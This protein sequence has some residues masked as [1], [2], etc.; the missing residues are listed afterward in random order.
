M[1]AGFVDACAA[2]DVD[3]IGASLHRLE[4]IG[5]PINPRVSSFK[6]AGEGDEVDFGQEV[7]EQGF[8]GSGTSSAPSG[9]TRSV[10]LACRHTRMPKA[11]ASE[12]EPC[13]DTAEPVDEQALARELVLALRRGCETMPR[14]CLAR[15]WSRPVWIC[16]H[17]REHER[18]RVLG[19]GVRVDS[20]SASPARTPASRRGAARSKRSYPGR[21]DLDEAK[22]RRVVEHRIVP[23][24]GKYEHVGFSRS[25]LEGVFHVPALEVA[26]AGLP[27]GEALGKVI[28]DVCEVHGELIARRKE[29]QSS[30]VWRQP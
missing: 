17:E 15:W 20:P 16:L 8:G 29:A 24:T 25:A 22:V 7:Q 6:R 27:P 14:Q 19:H 1:S 5:S 30:W 13:A 4:G 28:G 18:H 21:T 12:R 3:E 9:R 10:A 23:E 26:D 11:R 2:R